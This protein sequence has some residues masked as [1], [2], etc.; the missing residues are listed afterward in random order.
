MGRGRPGKGL[1][2]VDG[3]EGPE[4]TKARMRLIMQTLSG[5]VTVKEAAKTLGIS[6]S[7]FAALR[8]EVMQ[9]WLDV[10]APGTPGRPPKTQEAIEPSEVEALRK[11]VKELILDLQ[12]ANTRTEL[13]I[14]MPHVLKDVPKAGAEKGG[15]TP[16]RRNA[17]RW[18]GDSRSDTRGG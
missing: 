15:G 10:M 6:A 13:A 14:T 5:E 11:Q 16:K 17:K 12:V 8:Q 1:G 3:L 7:R 2:H 9:E 18:F 4:A